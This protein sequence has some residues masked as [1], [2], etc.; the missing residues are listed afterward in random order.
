METSPAV[1]EDVP[2]LVLHLL[3]ESLNF[4]DGILKYLRLLVRMFLLQ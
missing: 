3:S 4:L 1:I 2:A